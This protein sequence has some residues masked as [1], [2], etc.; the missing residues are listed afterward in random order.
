MS[1]KTETLRLQRTA[2]ESGG[3]VARLCPKCK[4]WLCSG[5]KEKFEQDY[6]EE[7]RCQCW[8]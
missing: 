1:R 3:Y 5:N 2:I 4:W 8:I 7:I 6:C